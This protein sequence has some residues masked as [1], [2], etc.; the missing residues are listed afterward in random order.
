MKGTGQ[1]GEAE[2]SGDKKGVRPVRWAQTRCRIKETTRPVAKGADGVSLC[3]QGDH[4]RMKEVSGW[5]NS[6]RG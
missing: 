5:E 1:S 2:Q 3:K 6:E 4:P